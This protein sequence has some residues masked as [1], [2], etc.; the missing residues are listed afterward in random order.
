MKKQNN[1]HKL[2]FLHSLL[3][4]HLLPSTDA[5]F[6]FKKPIIILSSAVTLQTFGWLLSGNQFFSSFN[7][8]KTIILWFAIKKKMMITII[9]KQKIHQHRSNK[10]STEHLSAQQTK[11]IVTKLYRAVSCSG[12]LAS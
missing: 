4:N 3:S 2:Q 1:H 9:I 8:T 12:M 11:M 6:P 7:L 10:W 5:N